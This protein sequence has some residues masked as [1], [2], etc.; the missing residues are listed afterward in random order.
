M[1]YTNQHLCN[2]K[3][4]CLP[5]D[6]GQSHCTPSRHVPCGHVSCACMHTN[7]VTQGFSVKGCRAALYCCSVVVL[8]DAF[9][10]HTPG[11]RSIALHTFQAPSMSPRIMRLHA[12]EFRYARFQCHQLSCC[13]VL[14]Q[15]SGAVRCVQTARAREVFNRR[16]KDLGILVAR[17]ATGFALLVPCCMPPRS[18]LRSCCHKHC[19]HGYCDSLRSMLLMP[20]QCP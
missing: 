10:L 14:L 18:K 20:M 9:T 15:R 6:V 4:G 19:Y 13:I 1:A 5:S 12:H 2:V 11:H 7:F 8:C 16:T 3:F 17:A